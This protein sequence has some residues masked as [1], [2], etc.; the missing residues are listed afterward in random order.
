MAAVVRPF[1]VVFGAFLRPK[2]RCRAEKEVGA[3]AAWIANVVVQKVL[4][5]ARAGLA[6]TQMVSYFRSSLLTAL[7]WTKA[8]VSVCHHLD[9]EVHWSMEM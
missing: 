3:I 9:K 5:D 2:Y 6:C 4:F 7:T 8:P 1:S